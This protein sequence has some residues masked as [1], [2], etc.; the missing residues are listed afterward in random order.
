MVEGKT[1]G[2]IL[3]VMG[4]W[5]NETGKE[6]LEETKKCVEDKEDGG[7]TIGVEWKLISIEKWK[8]ETVG[9]QGKSTKSWIPRGESWEN[10]DSIS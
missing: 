5:L 9:L 1:D 4:I 3:K 2:I 10:E 7:G 6:E 8:D